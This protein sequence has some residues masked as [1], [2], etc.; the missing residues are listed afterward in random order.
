MRMK[1][2]TRKSKKLE[3]LISV[4]SFLLLVLFLF[5][6]VTLANMIIGQL[7]NDFPGFEAAVKNR[8]V[9]RS[10]FLSL[11]AGLLATLI[12]WPISYFVMNNW[13]QDFAYRV[14][15]SPLYF[16]LAMALALVIA[17]LSVSFQAIR[18]ALTNPVDSL[19]YE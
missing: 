2:I 18:A 19:K 15:L 8:S 10:I 3:P 13:L 4:F 16:V 11:Y 12:A 6:S 9:L 14:S 5:I 17:I 7:L 1:P